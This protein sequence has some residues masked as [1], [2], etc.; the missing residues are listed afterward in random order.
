MSSS[1]QKP[2]DIMELYTSI[3]YSFAS[4]NLASCRRRRANIRCLDFK[5]FSA[6]QTFYWG[7]AMYESLRVDISQASDAKT[8]ILIVLWKNLSQISCCG[9]CRPSQNVV[10]VS[11]SRA[12]QCL[13]SRPLAQ[14]Q[15]VSRDAEMMQDWKKVPRADEYFTTSTETI[16]HGQLMME[17]NMIKLKMGPA[18]RITAFQGLPWFAPL[19]FFFTA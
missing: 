4:N 11:A 13:A 8:D 9:A 6:G 7:E 5:T 15:P 19:I 18:R 12:F 2:A 10:S 14:C 17:K 1:H 3:F 16:R